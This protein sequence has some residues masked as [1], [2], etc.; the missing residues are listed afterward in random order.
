MQRTA[1]SG[2]TEVAGIDGRALKNK[3][4]ERFEN[5]EDVESIREMFLKDTREGNPEG[6]LVWSGTGVGLINQIE[7]AAVSIKTPFG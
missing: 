4:V 6:M 3:V 1:Q 2:A 7:P 5:G